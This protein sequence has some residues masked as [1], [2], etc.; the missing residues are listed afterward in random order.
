MPI[1]K[2]ANTMRLLIEGFLRSDRLRI[3]FFCG[4]AIFWRVRH[5]RGECLIIC[6][7]ACFSAVVL[8]WR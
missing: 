5:Y 6:C 7:G 3:V 8:T 4:R 1:L 2:V